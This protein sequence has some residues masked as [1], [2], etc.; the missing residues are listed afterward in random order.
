MAFTQKISVTLPLIIAILCIAS[1]GIVGYQAYHSAAEM[2]HAQELE[3]SQGEWAT[4]RS[5]HEARLASLQHTILYTALAVMVFTQLAGQ[6]YASSISRKLKHMVTAMLS[7]RDGN[8]YVSVPYLGSGGEIGDLASALQSFKDAAQEMQRLSDKEKET[9]TRQQMRTGEVEKMVSQFDGKMQQVLSQLSAS[10]GSL[11]SLSQAMVNMTEVSH[12]RSKAVVQASE[13]TSNNVRAVAAAAEELSSSIHEISGQVARS[14]E[15]SRH[16]VQNT[17]SADGTVQALAQSAQKIGDVVN[18]IDDIAEQINL[19][20]LNATIESARAGEAG[21]G[22]AVVASEVKTL[23]SQTSKATQEIASQIKAIQ[24]VAKA[25]VDVLSGIRKTIN[26]L[27]E[28]AASIATSVEQQGA[29]TQEIARNMSTAATIVLEVSNNSVAVN[30]AAIE[31]D[32]SARNLLSAS[33]KM[34]E[35]SH[36]MRGEIEQFLTQIRAA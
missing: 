7:L 11:N 5:E 20:A 32:H 33:Q 28:I 12:G 29:A 10:S 9:L 18:L 26:E 14:A 16:A 8:V 2:L 25:V 27:N 30:E 21:K 24:D 31:T 3:G 36:A 6:F 4:G 22:F 13:V 34:S 15:I 17:Q 1:S 19:L 35:Q 23:A